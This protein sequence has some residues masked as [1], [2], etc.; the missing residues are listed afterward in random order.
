MS[1]RFL[2]KLDCKE[3]VA[4]RAKLQAEYKMLPESKS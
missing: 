2:K 4:R 3:M 1:V